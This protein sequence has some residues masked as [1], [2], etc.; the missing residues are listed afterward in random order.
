MKGKKFTH[1]ESPDERLDSVERTLG[2]FQRRLSKSVGV[3]VPPAPVSNYCE[4]PDAEGVV[5]R[6][7]FPAR[8]KILSGAVKIDNFP[9]DIKR[10]SLVADIITPD[11]STQKEFEVKDIVNLFTLEM[12]VEPGAR[13]ELRLKD[14]SISVSKI[15]VAFLYEIEPSK[16]KLQTE[17]VSKLEELGN[18]DA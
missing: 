16:S 8:G 2:H 11:L 14:P 10:L 18:F 5:L 3:M 12:S 13:F 7:M 9:A 4:A 15:W 1:G 6:Y 17:L